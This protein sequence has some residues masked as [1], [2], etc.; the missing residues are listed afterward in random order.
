VHA[1]DPAARERMSAIIKRGRALALLFA[2][3]LA[4]TSV[5]NAQAAAP[6]ISQSWAFLIGSTAAALLIVLAVLGLVWRLRSLGSKLAGMLSRQ[7]RDAAD[8]E[9]RQ[10]EDLALCKTELRNDLEALRAA[11][12]KVPSETGRALGPA[13][14][15]L[16]E[17]SPAPPRSA[18]PVAESYPEARGADDGV[19]QLLVIANRIVQE[20]STTLESFRARTASLAARVSPWPRGSEGTPV[21]FVVEHH[22]S[23]YA[24]P[25]VV[26][27]ARLPQ[28]WFNRAEFGV[29]DEIHRVVSLPRLKRR[30][31]AYDVQEPG[32]FER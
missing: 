1:A 23:C 20:S 30:G 19:A 24:I 9:K 13:L 17:E 12:A 7:D 4:M 29:N 26:K 28:D 3:G 5:T 18:P 2:A 6:N 16:R 31:D 11:I 25:N 27:P 21:A 14:L 32:V 22:G 10:R 15:R 8:R